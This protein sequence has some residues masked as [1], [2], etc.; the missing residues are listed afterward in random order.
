MALNN[1][2]IHKAYKPLP[3][4]YSSHFASLIDRLLEKKPEKRLDIKGALDFIP[5]SIKMQYELRELQIEREGEIY[6]PVESFAEI[7]PGRVKIKIK[8]KSPPGELVDI[9]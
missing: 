8:Q 6:R 1:S 7:T 5:S 3:P 9:I 4:I 2:I